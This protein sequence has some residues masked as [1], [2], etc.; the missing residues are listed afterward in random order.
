V[1]RA[2]DLETGA[3]VAVKVLR[4]LGRSSDIQRFSRE[5]S[6]LANLANPGI[7]KY[8][9]HGSTRDGRH[10]MVMEWISGET[11]ALRL[12]RRGLTV[13]ESV[14]VA[15]QAAE[16]LEEVHRAGVIH[17]DLTPRNLMFESEEDFQVKLVDFGVA[18]RQGGVRL[19]RTG[20]VVGSPGYMAPEQAR[21]QK[22]LDER[23]DVFALGCI[24]YEC[25][26]GRPAFVGDAISLPM[27]VLFADPLSVREINQAVSPALDF[28]VRRMLSKSRLHRP[29]GAG[30]LASEL[31]ALREAETAPRKR[32]LGPEPQ[33]QTVVLDPERGTTA[34][35]ERAA[36]WSSLTF[37]LLIG[38][39]DGP[40]A[41]QEQTTASRRLEIEALL[42][43]VG[44]LHNSQIE[45]LDGGMIALKL[46]INASPQEAAEQVAQATL[47]LR[48]HF[49]GMAMALVAETSASPNMD[50]L[51]ERATDSLNQEDMSSLFG[52]SVGEASTEGVIRLDPVAQQLLQGRYPL[53][54]KE[55]GVYLS[56][57]SLPR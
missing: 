49:P 38:P 56:T 9:A 7:V 50:S 46:A 17:R 34:V 52:D 16:A 57:R 45:I 14:D 47:P 20:I 31:S 8:L 43:G 55:S 18:R 25:L 22:D 32:A 23:V 6:L 37:L 28:L 41:E 44:V 36:F 5:S 29:K 40:P 12:Q 33:T 51:I 19:T 35:E 26:T 27:K 54:V 42:K 4:P 48:A 30:E 24:L 39:A 53:V 2:R 11:L 10:Y 13:V 3:T 1:Y 21:G 15:R